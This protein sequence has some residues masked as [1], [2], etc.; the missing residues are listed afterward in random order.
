[1]TDQKEKQGFY[2][3]RAGQLRRRVPPWMVDRQVLHI[4]V[5]LA[6]SWLLFL[7]PLDPSASTLL[8]SRIATVLVFIGFLTYE[9]A[10]D[11][12]VRDWGFRDIEG[13]TFGLGAGSAAQIAAE[14]MWD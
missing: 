7:W 3:G 11:W 2:Q 8:G 9:L 14:V 5:G 1:M 6:L 4:P 12:R 13:F 10:E